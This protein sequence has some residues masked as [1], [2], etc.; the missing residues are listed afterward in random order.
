MLSKIESFFKEHLSAS[1][2][3]TGRQIEARL[4]IA[5]TVLFLEMAYSD[6]ELHE[7][8][9]QH[10][11]QTLTDLYGLSTE[12]IEDLVDIAKDSRENRQDI[13]VFTNL[14]KDNFDR[15]QKIHIVEQ[16]WQLIYADGH[17]DK[18]EDALIRKIT[19]LLGLEHGEMIQAKM[20]ARDNQ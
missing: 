6:F 1:D 11:R 16:L 13:W 18:Y 3:E 14:L 7:D 5:T 19:N 20:K 12:E 2:Q 9:Q 4:K 15:D 10:I 17:V 8:E